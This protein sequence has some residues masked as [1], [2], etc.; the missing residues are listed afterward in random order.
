M[1]TNK[2]NSTIEEP[3][4]LGIKIGTKE[5]SAWTQIRDSA[6]IEVDNNKRAII[7]GENMVK[8]ANEM[9]EKEKDAS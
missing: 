6:Q 9:I 1:E 5:E 2:E 3:E 8:L 4:D 7:I